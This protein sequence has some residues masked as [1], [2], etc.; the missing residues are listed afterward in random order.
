M[1]WIF[2]NR[3]SEN[4]EMSDWSRNAANFRDYSVGIFAN[5][6]QLKGRTIYTG[7]IREPWKSA[8][9]FPMTAARLAAADARVAQVGGC[10]TRGV[11][12]G[13]SGRGFRGR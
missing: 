2:P 5:K 6:Q 8:H 1:V 9:G 10:S 11:A 12:M 3:P 4:I 7:D 13:E